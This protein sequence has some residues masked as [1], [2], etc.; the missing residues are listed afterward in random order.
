M[1][2]DE[3]ARKRAQEYEKSQKKADKIMLG[4]ALLLM[5]VLARCGVHQQRMQQKEENAEIVREFF[6][7]QA[8]PDASAQAADSAAP[9]AAAPASD[10]SAP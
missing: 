9:D 10:A 2:D 3:A 5:L 6:Q 4:V 7:Q 8:A 1:M